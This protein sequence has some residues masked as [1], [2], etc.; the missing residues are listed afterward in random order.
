MG[1]EDG[2]VI[3]KKKRHYTK[4]ICLLRGCT[5]TN[6]LHE[7]KCSRVERG[8]GNGEKQ[9]PEALMLKGMKLTEMESQEDAI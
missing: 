1:K 3:T 6:I 2:L 8:E 5:E 4:N 9:Q 7:I